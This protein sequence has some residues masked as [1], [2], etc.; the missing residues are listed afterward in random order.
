[1]ATFERWT[2]Y[3]SSPPTEISAG[4]L[5]KLACDAQPG[6]VPPSARAGG[7]AD[8]E[9]LARPDMTVLRLNRRAPP[10]LPLAAFGPFWR[11]F[12]EQ[13]AAAASAPVDYVAATLIASASALIGNARWARATPG[14]VEPPHLWCASVGDSGGGKSPGADALQRDILPKI[15][16]RMTGDFSDRLRDWQTQAES[17]KASTEAWQK[18]IREA[19]KT[20]H[21]PPLPPTREPPPEPQAPR[22]RQTDV[23]IER[24]ASLLASAAPKGLLIVRDELAGWLL[25]MNSYNDAGRQ[26]WIEAYGGRPY[27]VERQ[28]NPLPIEVPRLA[29]AVFGG[30][31]PDRLARMLHDAD[32]GLLARFCWFWPEPVLFDL[33]RAAPGVDAATEALD[34]LRMLDLV[35]AS[36]PLM[37]PLA[38]DAVP[39][40]AEFGRDMQAR[41]AEAGGL[42]LSA[43]GKARGT[44]LRLS[45]VLEY[46]WWCGDEGMSPPPVTITAR[47]FT[48][49]AHLVADYLIPMA[50]RVYGDAAARPEDR[51]AA[52]LARWIVKNRPA[53][54][55]VRKLQREMRLPG[56]S[57]AEAIHGAARV[58]LEAGW[59]MPPDGA[60]GFQQRQRAAYPVNPMV[61]EVAP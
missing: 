18:D 38:D 7:R 1:V 51:N 49:G 19:Q 13:A 60:T 50:E 29:V 43:L 10:A 55:Y 41:Q 4:K 3:Q 58:L 56:L 61:W 34:R 45:L 42:M 48:A 6:W 40:I 25:G 12:I 37:V 23:T 21:A 24:V 28:K 46:L 44:A 35:P 14:W 33:S 26:F 30:T 57:T 31:Q 52:T 5:F 27:R 36:R 15:E 47:A 8:P 53:E 9:L 20:G 32:D 39:L 17:Y 11:R 2:H 16:S 22:L 54:V 59:L